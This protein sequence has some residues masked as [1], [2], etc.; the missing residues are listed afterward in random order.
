MNHFKT[1]RELVE[2]W[3]GDSDVKIAIE[4]TS[5]FKDYE[6]KAIE[7]LLKSPCFALTWDIGHSKKN[8]ILME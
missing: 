2:K 5:G 6:I 8:G 1:F 7:Y 4:N 3:I